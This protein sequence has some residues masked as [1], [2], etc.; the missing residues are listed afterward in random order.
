MIN[1]S[2]S[3]NAFEIMRKTWSEAWIFWSGATHVESKDLYDINDISQKKK[4]LLA[5]KKI[6]T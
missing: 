5:C 4:L 2:S 6:M 1:L 3:K